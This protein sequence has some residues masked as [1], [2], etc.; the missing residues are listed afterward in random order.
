[1]LVAVNST[2]HPTERWTL[3]QLIEAF[4]FDARLSDN[5]THTLR[6]TKRLIV[7]AR[8]A[9]EGYIAWQALFDGAPKP[10]KLPNSRQH[11]DRRSDHQTG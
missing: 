3:Q 4:R 5:I 10:Q 7:V 8:Q 1:M 11:G 2:V 6:R 9:R